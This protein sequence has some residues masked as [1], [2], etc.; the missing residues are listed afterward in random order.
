M[1]ACGL[2][3][4][5]I[6]AGYAANGVSFGYTRKT[7][8]DHAL[9]TALDRDCAVWRVIHGEPVCLA[10]RTDAAGPTDQAH[11]SGADL[12][13]GAVGDRHPELLYADPA[14]PPATT[15]GHRIGGEAHP[16]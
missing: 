4:S 9:S 12:A 6:V 2:P 1:A 8:S 15:V 16:R 14:P 3:A 10:R 7:V 11:I 13:D 5:A